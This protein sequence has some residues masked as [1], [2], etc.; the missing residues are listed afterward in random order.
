MGEILAKRNIGTYHNRGDDA[1]FQLH[2]EG[3]HLYAS[4]FGFHNTGD[5]FWANESI[6][7]AWG[8]FARF[9]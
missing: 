6:G 3:K 1:L 4:T 8:N 7:G 5:E 9:S 2:L